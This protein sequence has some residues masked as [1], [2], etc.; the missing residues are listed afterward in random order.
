TDTA[1]NVTTKD[2]TFTFVAPPITPTFDLDNGTDTG[3]KGDQTTLLANATLVGHTTAGATVVLKDGSNNT[4]ATQTADGSGN[5]TFTPVA[6][7]TGSNSFTVV[8]T[9][10]GGFTASFPRTI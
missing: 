1:G 10:T 5:F 2:V 4:L 9:I 8:P 6:L 3:T 7:A